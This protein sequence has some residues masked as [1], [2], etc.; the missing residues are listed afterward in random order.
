LAALGLADEAGVVGKSAAR[1]LTQVGLAAVVL[2]A[3][4]G[5]GLTRLLLPA[6]LRRHEPLWILPVG[7]CAVALSMTVL[8][9][10]YVPFKLSLAIVLAAGAGL[11]AVA[12]RRSGP[13]RGF[14]ARGF[15][16]PAYIAV[17][18][19]AVA[20]IPLFR[21]GFATVEGQGQ[22]AHLAV[23]TA[24]FLQ[25]HHPTAVAPEE[26][27]DRVPLVWRSKPPIYYAL[28]AVASL[29]GMEVFET[30]STLAA[31]LLALATIGF[32]LVARELLR[33]PPWVALAVMGLVGLDRMVLHTVM[34]PYFNQTWG[35]FAMP[36][37]L[38]LAWWV[39]Q[40]RTR[41]GVALLAMFTAVLAFAYPLALPVALIPLA[42][43]VW[44]ERRAV[45]QRVYHGR[46]SLLWMVPLGLVLFIPLA[47]VIEKAAGA[48][49]VVFDPG[50][51]LTS[52]GG[53]LT[54]Y[55]E[56]QQF[57]GIEPLWLF[58]AAAPALAYGV[59][60]ALRDCPRALRNGLLAVMAFAA[61]FAV[62]FRFRTLGWYFHFKVLAFVAPLALAVAAVGLARVRTYRLGMV[63]VLA[64]LFSA[65][66]SAGQELGKTFDE[67]PRSTLQ[68]RSIDAQLP[69]GRSIRL[70]IDPQQQ[71][72]VAFM[73]HG[74]PL[75]SRL[76]LLHTSYPH[77][78]TSRRADYIL[79]PRGA[80]V[81]ADALPTPVR[82]LDAY[83]LYR[84]R[85]GVP[86]RENCSRT[87]VQ[88][89]ERIT[90]S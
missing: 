49:T 4:A 73:L 52:W 26:P 68:L 51:P 69:P 5:F 90:V 86:G 14:T 81:P 19:T 12:W 77:V 84:Q 6:G 64:L 29:S 27:V 80:R 37:A 13:P 53:D 36:F 47:G 16:W 79:T 18:V 45:A 76:P 8:G 33:A 74:Q 41:G 20:L 60:L 31:V 28:G 70:D 48:A 7:A 2:F 55:F 82:R 35:F 87:M 72:W 46:R 17:L 71:N 22:D 34:H 30:I 83:T 40:E 21:A 25:K 59:W 44:P 85:S 63:A 50:Y 23:G 62:Y 58:A 54:A 75:C 10:A 57:F 15:A 1:P 66:H 78:P 43:V 24:Q 61:V 39:T 67:L 11:G 32:F 3:V 42:V 65:R 88:T 9:Y 56:E 89:V 38:V